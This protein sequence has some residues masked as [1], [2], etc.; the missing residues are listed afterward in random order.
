[1]ARIDTPFGELNVREL[2]NR[3]AGVVA[4]HGFT[5]HGGSF[6]ELAELLPTGLAAVDLPGHGLS[7]V[8][9][10]DYRTTI[11][12]VAEYFRSFDD[13]VDLI[14]YSQGGRI[15]LG[16]GLECPG[17]IR[18]LM[19]IS[20]SPGI[21]SLEQRRQRHSSD[22]RLAGRIEEGGIEAFVDEWLGLE[23]FAGLAQRSDDWRRRD[24]RLRLDNTAKGLAAA[25]RGYGQGAQPY[26][27]DRLSGLSVPTLFIAGADDAKYRSLAEQMAVSV[28]E[29][30]VALV[31]GAGHAVVGEQ[32]VRVS[33]LL[34]AWTDPLRGKLG[35]R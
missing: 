33:E 23:I 12:V 10:I 28:P 27:G 22:D 24:R 21:E 1:M 5:Q 9:P 29:S 26:L 14:G 3:P 11:S 7:A 20:A 2:G 34:Q 15:A 32:P 35:G 13:A 30:A 8:D 6:E 31:D 19:L 16:L 25:L 18:S 4:L 17:L